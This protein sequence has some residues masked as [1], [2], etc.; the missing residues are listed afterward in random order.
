MQGEELVG[1]TGLEPA[2]SCTPCMRSSQLSYIPTK[3][4][5]RREDGSDFPSR[6]LGRYDRVHGKD[7]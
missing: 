2:T 4:G 3:N 7:P 5:T 6:E 1:M